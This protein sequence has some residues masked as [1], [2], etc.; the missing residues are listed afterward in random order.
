MRKEGGEEEEERE[1]ERKES[2]RNSSYFFF[3][4]W[5]Q[6]I[7]V[8]SFSVDYYVTGKG[9]SP[10]F[11]DSPSKCPFPIIFVLF[12]FFFVILPFFSY[13]LSL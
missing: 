10:S 4:Y 12:T 2:Q 3:I 9:R 6:V 8:N 7:A 5:T 11:Q 13:Y 1:R